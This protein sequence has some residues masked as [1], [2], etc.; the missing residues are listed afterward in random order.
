MQ[1]QALNSLECEFSN[2]MFVIYYIKVVFG[3]RFY[4]PVTYEFTLVRQ[5]VRPLV[6]PLVRLLVRHKHISVMETR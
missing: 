4:K 3:H 1:L 6:C 2:W 5:L